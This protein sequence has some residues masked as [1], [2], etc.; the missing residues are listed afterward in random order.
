MKAKRELTVTGTV[1][2]VFL[3]NKGRGN[4]QM[5]ISA[6]KAEALI[7]NAGLTP[8]ETEDRTSEKGWTNLGELGL[9]KNE[10]DDNYTLSFWRHSDYLKTM[11]LSKGD[12]IK[13]SPIWN[14]NEEGES[15]TS[16]EGVE[17]EIPSQYDGSKI[18]SESASERKINSENS[19]K[20]DAL[21]LSELFK[22]NP[23][24]F[25]AYVA[26]KEGK[27]L[28]QTKTTPESDDE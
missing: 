24:M 13:I 5:T 1:K 14:P 19:A 11:G 21:L 10:D 12:D 17:K 4:F 20:K 3:P 28:E 7:T 18:S 22:T 25:A 8:E 23:A 9:F 6:E 26:A 2:N 15:Y 16:R 27:V